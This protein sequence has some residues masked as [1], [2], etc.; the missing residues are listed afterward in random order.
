VTRWWFALLLA[1]VL[2]APAAWTV[3]PDERLADAALEARARVL[4]LG[5]AAILLGPRYRA[6][7]PEPEPLNPA[8]RRELARLQR[9]DQGP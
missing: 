3:E 9:E 6:T 8:E 1:L 4:W 2:L 7:P 5:G